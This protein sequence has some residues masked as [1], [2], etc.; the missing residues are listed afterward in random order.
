[1]A[2]GVF[3][4]E[5]LYGL[6][7]IASDRRINNTCISDAG[8]SDASNI[9]VIQI[10]PSWARST[11]RRRDPGASATARRDQPT[12][13][14]C[15]H[16]TPPPQ[17]PSLHRHFCRRQRQ[18]TSLWGREVEVLVRPAACS[19]LPVGGPGRG[20]QT[21]QA[22]PVKAVARAT[23]AQRQA[24]V[25]RKA[26]SPGRRRVAGGRVPAQVMHAGWRQRQVRKRQRF[27][28]NSHLHAV[29]GAEAVTTINNCQPWCRHP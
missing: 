24:A 10:R 16:R 2:R 3:A 7:N 20:V 27:S 19:S 21:P 5:S 18:G 12:L 4:R 13:T 26:C 6:C 9:P 14:P 17:E 11:S 15:H 25:L 28:L 29:T 22:C 8:I 1:M 23:S